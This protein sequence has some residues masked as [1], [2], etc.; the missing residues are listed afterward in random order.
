MDLP[1]PAGIYAPIGQRQILF[2]LVDLVKY[3]SED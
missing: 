2:A 1:V 3:I